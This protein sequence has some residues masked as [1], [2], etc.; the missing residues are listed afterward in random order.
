MAQVIQAANRLRAFQESDVNRI[1]SQGVTTISSVFKAKGF[2]VS[3][4]QRGDL[5]TFT[6]TRGDESYDLDT[7]VADKGC[8][9]LS[10]NND[11]GDPVTTCMGSDDNAAKQVLVVRKITNFVEHL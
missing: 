6:F 2:K 10:L 3:K 1:G 11:E 7:I 9:I 8:C 5:L 4:N